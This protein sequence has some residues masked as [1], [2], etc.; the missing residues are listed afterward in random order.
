[1]QTDA[2]FNINKLK[3]IFSVLVDVTNTLPSFPVGYCFILS[4]STEAFISI[5]NCYKEIFF[6]DDC[7]SPK[8]VLGD[9]LLRISASMTRTSKTSMA[10]NGIKQV[11]Q[12]IKKADLIVASTI[13]QLCSW[14]PAEAVKAQR[15]QKKYLKHDKKKIPEYNL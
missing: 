5:Y 2:T 14:H 11:F 7:P 1:M 12:L 13:L 9:F 8:V 15:V 6:E 10:E 3:M 4:E